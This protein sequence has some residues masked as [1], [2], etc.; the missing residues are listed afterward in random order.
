MGKHDTIDLEPVSVV[1]EEIEFGSG[2]NA[3][4]SSDSPV[5]IWPVSSIEMEG[6]GHTVAVAA[7]HPIVAKR[8]K[9]LLDAAELAVE[10]G[11]APSYLVR[12]QRKYSSVPQEIK[13][14]ALETE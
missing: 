4:T 8:L 9:E 3:D 11:E 10:D 1:D 14:T 12:A 7:F 5:A 6:G 2:P 13:E